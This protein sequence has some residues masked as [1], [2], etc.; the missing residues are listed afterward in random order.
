MPL[1]RLGLVL[2]SPAFHRHH[3]GRGV[4]AKNLGGMLSAWDRLFGTAEEPA[5]IPCGVE[6]DVDEGVVGL[7]VEPFVRR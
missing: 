2:V 1:G 6:R 7:L 5:V 4:G 3:H